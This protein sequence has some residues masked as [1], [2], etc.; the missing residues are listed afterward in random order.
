[1]VRSSIAAR[2]WT[3]EEEALLA[4]LLAEGK[5]LERI[6]AQLKRTIASV[7][8]RATDLRSQSKATAS[9]KFTFRDYLA[10]RRSTYTQEWELLKDLKKEAAFHDVG[11]W[12][13]IDRYLKSRDASLSLRSVARSVWV[14][15]LQAKRKRR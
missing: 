9:G 13:D 1:M 5:D 14:S 10:A 15:Y 12:E 7:Q 8:R 4:Q 2:L 3:P 6:A 11:S